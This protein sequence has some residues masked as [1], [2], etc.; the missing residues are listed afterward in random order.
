MNGG[1]LKFHI[2]N[3]G[4]AAGFPESRARFY[5][6]EI[7]LGLEHL[8]SLRIVYRDLKP[9]NILIDDHG[10]LRISD[11]GLAVEIDQHSTLKGRVGTA[12]YMGKRNI[13]NFSQTA[14]PVVLVVATASHFD[15]DIDESRNV[16][17][18]QFLLCT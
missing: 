7:T 11:L 5:T 3:M 18:V 8:H 1:D 16:Q 10:H 14:L 6:A 13:H 9:E 17:P 2:H 4:S 12:G 15:N